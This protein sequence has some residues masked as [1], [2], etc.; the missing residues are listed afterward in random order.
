MWQ[1]SLCF[2]QDNMA[3]QVWGTVWP[4]SGSGIDFAILAKTVQQAYTEQSVHGR[5]VC[6]AGFRLPEIIGP[7]WGTVWTTSGSGMD[8]A[9]PDK[10]VWRGV[11]KTVRPCKARQSCECHVAACMQRHRGL[12]TDGVGTM[13]ASARQYYASSAP[14]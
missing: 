9:I 13:P 6:L 3:G 5:Q 10:T 11:N 1:D 7:D 12:A 14:A 2:A 4:A 8:L